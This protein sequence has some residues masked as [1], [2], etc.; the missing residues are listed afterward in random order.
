MGRQGTSG[1]PPIKM[2][3]DYVNL[4]GQD[5]ELWRI[6]LCDPTPYPRTTTRAHHPQ[7]TH[8]QSTAATHANRTLHAPTPFLLVSMVLARE[9]DS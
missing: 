1:D 4:C 2:V 6:L 5:L 3:L 9:P 7:A 8:L